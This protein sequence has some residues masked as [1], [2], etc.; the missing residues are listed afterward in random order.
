MGLDS[1]QRPLGWGFLDFTGITVPPARA[2]RPLI[3]DRE[4]SGRLRQLAAA[5]GR[6]SGHDVDGSI[7]A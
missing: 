3:L 7:A 6:E 2:P 1:R 5:V 4:L